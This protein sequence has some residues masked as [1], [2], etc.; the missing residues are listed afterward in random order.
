VGP[1]GRRAGEDLNFFGPARLGI[2]GR[3]VQRCV[4]DRGLGAAADPNTYDQP[5]AQPTARRNQHGVV[6]RCKTVASAGPVFVAW[7]TH[8]VRPDHHTRRAKE[9]RTRRRVPRRSR[10]RHP[11]GAPAA[12]RKLRA[13]Q[14]AQADLSALVDFSLERFGADTA[15]RYLDAL[16]RTYLSGQRAVNG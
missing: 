15:V 2:V 7:H 12:A 9:R 1:L 13:H 3:S 6:N 5:A 11:S 8:S 16:E 14:K 4:R 10:D